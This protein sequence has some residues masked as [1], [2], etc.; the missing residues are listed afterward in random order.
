MD[1]PHLP[2]IGATGALSPA[3]EPLLPA[4]A[5]ELT[6]T[7]LVP[8]GQVNVRGDPAD[9]RFASKTGAVLGCVLPTAPNSVQTA[10]DVTVMWLGPDEWLVLT[11]PGAET[12]MVARLQE[13]LAETPSSIVD[14]SG[15]RVQLRLS[16]D[17]ARDVLAKG[18]PLDL[19]PR[20]FRPGQSHR[21]CSRAPPCSSTWST[22]GRP[23]ICSR[24]ALSLCICGMAW[25][26][27]ARVWRPGAQRRLRVSV[28]RPRRYR[29]LN[30]TR[31]PPASLGHGPMLLWRGR[32]LAP[33]R[34]LRRSRPARMIERDCR[35]AVPRRPRGER[36]KPEGEWQGEGKHGCTRRGRVRVWTGSCATSR[37]RY[38]SRGQPT[39]ATL[40]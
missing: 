24:A 40:E 3:T 1:E 16:G 34:G 19:H 33:P 12:D 32:F 21:R 14:V 23:S 20:V 4:G 9:Q 25:R 36:Q 8:P 11:E 28:K 26:R 38:G 5:G 10:A 39:A 15:N 31:L 29:G 37:A 7:E 18:C 30:R 27:D 6:L 35:E 22:I 2:R 13:A 17:H